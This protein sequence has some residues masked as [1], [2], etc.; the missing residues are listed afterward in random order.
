MKDMKK[1]AWIEEKISS[2]TEGTK[3][4]EIDLSAAKHAVSEEQT[5]RE[6]ARRRMRI[7]LASACACVLL[8]AFVTAFLLPGRADLGPAGEA[9]P[10]GG[11]QGPAASDPS[12]G[13]GEGS[14]APSVR[15]ELATAKRGTAGLNELAATYGDRLRKLTDL[16]LSA[17]VNAAY[18]VYYVEDEA[19][20][21]KTELLYLQ[22]GTRV[23]A[24]VYTDLSD[25]KYRAEELEKYGLLSLKNGA[26]MYERETLVNGEYVCYGTFTAAGD[27]YCV[28]LQ[29]SSESAFWELMDYLV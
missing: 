17:S 13:D 3:D 20:L 1:D 16:G 14:S 5:R 6:S 29:S 26:Y 21:L 7:G 23:I 2:Y 8:A 25:G 28:E 24:T 11:S 10:P 19:V 15:Y 27:E 4:V 9:S 12:Q 22:T 18:T